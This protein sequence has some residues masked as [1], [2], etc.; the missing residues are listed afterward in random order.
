MRITKS[1][2]SRHPIEKQENLLV[3]IHLVFW[4]FLQ[5]D[6]EL[7]SRSYVYESFRNKGSIQPIKVHQVKVGTFEE[8][9]KFT[10]DNSQA[11]ANQYK[12]PRVLKTKEAVSVLLK[13]VVNEL[14]KSQIMKIEKNCVLLSYLFHSLGL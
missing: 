8:L 6:R 3:V 1:C 13:N 4:V 9:R 11:S 5:I 10:I 14:W 2:K 12:V 7:C